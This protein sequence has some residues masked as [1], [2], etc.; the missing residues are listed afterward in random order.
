[1]MNAYFCTTFTRVDISWLSP[2]P[3]LPEWGFDALLRTDLYTNA[4]THVAISVV[5]PDRMISYEIY[6]GVF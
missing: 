1:M 2:A 5:G 6:N 4:T 3:S